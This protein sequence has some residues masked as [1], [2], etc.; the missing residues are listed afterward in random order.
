M[1]LDD[2]VVLQRDDGYVRLREGSWVPRRYAR[3]LTARRLRTA[4]SG[5]MGRTHTQLKKNTY[6]RKAPHT[7]GNIPACVWGKAVARRE[8]ARSG[9]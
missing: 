6:Y 5:L 8:E 9:R 1:N 4:A 2:P 7:S 3:R